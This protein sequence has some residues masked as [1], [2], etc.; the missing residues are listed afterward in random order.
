MTFNAYIAAVGASQTGTN[1]EY[2]VTATQYAK[3][4]TLDFNFGG[5]KLQSQSS[6]IYRSNWILSVTIPFPKYAQ[7]YPRKVTFLWI[8]T[9]NIYVIILKPDVDGGPVFLGPT[10]WDRVYLVLDVCIHISWS[11]SMVLS[12]LFEQ[13]TNSRIGLAPNH[14][15]NYNYYSWS[16]PRYS[17]YQLD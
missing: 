7:A 11:I 5:G 12:S 1:G 17:C 10:F 16:H 9:Y 8:F 15:L 14:Y 6:N 2:T 3:M 13:I 4:H